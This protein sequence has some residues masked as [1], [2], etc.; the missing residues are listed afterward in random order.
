MERI[1][2]PVTAHEDD[3]ESLTRAVRVVPGSEL[4]GELAAGGAPVGG[5]VDADVVTVE[6]RGGCCVARPV[7]EGVPEE[8]YKTL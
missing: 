8:T 7:E 2:V 1:D 5:E 4:W 3:L 6:G